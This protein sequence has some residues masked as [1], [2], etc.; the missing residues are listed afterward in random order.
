[1]IALLLPVDSGCAINNHNKNGDYSILASIKTIK[2][3]DNVLM[4]LKRPF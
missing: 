4:L 3:K 2:T 1:M